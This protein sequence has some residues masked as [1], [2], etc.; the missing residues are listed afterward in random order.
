MTVFPLFNEI[1][2]DGM[3]IAAM[4]LVKAL[5]TQGIV[6]QPIHAWREVDFPE[7]EEECPL[8][9]VENADYGVDSE[10]LTRMVEKINTLAKPGDVVIN[11]GSPNWLAC[12]PYLNP[13][14]RVITAVHSIN[15]S[16]LKL[17]RAYPERVSAFVCIS[18][19]VMTRF[20]KKLP[21]QFHNRVVLIPN[22]VQDCPMPKTDYQVHTPLKIL[23][24][25]RIEATSKGCDKIPKVL[26]KL[27]KRGIA[28]QCDFYGYFH[29]WE[30][31]FWACVDKAEVRDCVHYCGEV[32]H[33]EIYKLMPAYDVFLAPSNFEGFPL[34]ISEAMMCGMPCVVSKID[35]VTDWIL[36]PSGGLYPQ[37]MDIRGFANA[38]ERIA[39]VP[40][41]A[42]AFGKTARA[43]IIELASFEAHGRNYAQLVQKV[44]V[45]QNYSLIQPSCDLTNYVHPECL[46]PWGLARILPVGLKTFLRRFM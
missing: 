16:T 33:D 22:A 17:C 7:Y 30:T 32:A 26:A 29:N 20:L 21:K 39:K 40:G 4:T 2:R 34:S 14:I 38:L 18:Q 35:G 46:K 10:H 45:E 12:V 44:S 13:E 1:K 31:Q 6:V 8:L 9:F 5:R 23:Y 27:K 43:R 15:P 41:L 36:G 42:E 28:A 19:G 25:G 11:F 3:G 37:K 24:V